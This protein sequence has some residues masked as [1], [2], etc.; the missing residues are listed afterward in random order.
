M[1]N[2]KKCDRCGGFYVPTLKPQQLLVKECR[3]HSWWELDFCDKCYK[4]LQDFLKLNNADK[5]D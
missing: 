5:E 3:Q 1:A 2:A 4:E